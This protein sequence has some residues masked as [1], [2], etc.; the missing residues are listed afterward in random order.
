VVFSTRDRTP[1]LT[2]EIRD[3]L[4]PYITGIL[5]NIG[6][7]SIQ[8]GGVEDH[9]H[10]LCHLSRT[11]TLAQVIEKVKTSTSK[12]MK[13]KGVPGFSWQAGYGAFSVGSSEADRVIA[14]IKGHEEH[15]RT[16]EFRDE[17]RGMLIQAGM[18]FD[19]RFLWD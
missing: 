12:W 15:H 1:W 3:E 7:P 19:E 11:A 2:R 5:K 13:A 18:E 8:T 4:H 14:Y 17:L 9:V 10:I 16:I 6:C